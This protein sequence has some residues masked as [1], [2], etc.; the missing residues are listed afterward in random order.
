MSK[1]SNFV[2]KINFRLASFV[3]IRTG[4][5]LDAH[6]KRISREKDLA[7]GNLFK[8]QPE[9]LYA[10][11]GDVK[12]K[13][14]RES[15]LD[16][17]IYND[18]FEKDEAFFLN[19]LL[20]KGD[21]FVDVGSNVGYFTLQASKA[22]GNEG[23][24]VCFEPSPVTYKRLLENIALNGFK[25]ITAVNK[26]LSDKEGKMSLNISESGYDAWNT[27]AAVSD[28]KFH[29]TV[30]V[31]VSTLD[32][33]LSNFDKG[34]ISLVKIDVEGWEKFAL[35][36]SKD[37]FTTYSPVLMIEFT[38]ENTY[39]AGYFVQEIYDILAGWGY[40]WFRFE[41]KTLTPE[42]RRLH[43]PYDNLIAT[44]DIELLRS[45]LR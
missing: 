11:D 42:P 16:R 1:L 25:N 35:L 41:N 26:G 40:Q 7:W 19:R 45:K 15:I 32:K 13:M 21:T 44:K 5:M 10:L 43:Y 22:V 31:E 37:F 12:I 9:F 2:N 34:K 18:G 30:S 14:H 23:N 8:E 24:V 39:A 17:W 4:R 29:S 36:G 3:N 33:E 6:E 27:F 28:N 20:K 38:E